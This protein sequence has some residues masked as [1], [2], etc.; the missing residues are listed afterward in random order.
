MV[1]EKIGLTKKIE[2]GL[3]LL[4]L[5]LWKIDLD[6]ENVESGSTFYLRLVCEKMI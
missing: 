5:G 4:E 3:E 6:Y 2:L 1:C